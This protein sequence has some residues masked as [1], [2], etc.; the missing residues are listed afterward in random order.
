VQVISLPWRAYALHLLDNLSR[1]LAHRLRSGRFD[2]LLQDELNHPSLFWLNRRL[3]EVL[4]YPLISIVHHLRCS[5]QRQAWQNHFYSQIERR[6]LSSVDGFV[7]NSQTTLRAVEGLE[8]DLTVRPHVVACPAGDQFAPHISDIEVDHRAAEP[9]PLRV[10]FL[11]NLIPR[12]GLHTLLAALEGT[13]PGECEL[14]VVGGQQV[15]PR[16]V[17]AIRRQIDRAGLA[18]RVRLLGALGPD[19]LPDCLRSHHL[20]AVPSSY[21]GY[22]IV[23]L[24][25]MAS[26]LPAIATTAGAAGEIITDSV[27]GYLVPPGDAPALAQ[28][29]RRLAGDRSLLAAM[30]LAAR[31]RYRAQPTWVQTAGVIR[32]FLLAQI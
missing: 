19:E 32:D 9:G 13:Y 23:Y 11:G 3:K 1:S 15:A 14:T 24:E 6:Y 8:V 29:L 12:K 16:Y 2:V 31:R 4:P 20:M 5:E 30:S 25:G 10:L 7:F 26:G 21:E 18:S 27:D 28:C 22:G 17:R